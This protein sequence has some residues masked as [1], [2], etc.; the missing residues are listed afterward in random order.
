MRCP[1]CGGTL[2]IPEAGGGGPDGAAEG[3]EGGAGYATSYGPEREHGRP[4][5]IGP[6]SGAD[7]SGLGGGA[8]GGDGGAPDLAEQAVAAAEPAGEGGG[9]PAGDGQG[10]MASCPSCG[11]RLALARAHAG[12][13]MRCPACAAAFVVPGAGAPEWDAYL[14]P[15]PAAPPDILAGTSDTD[16]WRQEEAKAQAD[17]LNERFAEDDRARQERDDRG[18][19]MAAEDAHRAA[20]PPDFAQADVDRALAEQEQERQERDRGFHREELEGQVAEL[21]P[22]AEEARQR[23]EGRNRAR[24]EGAQRRLRGRALGAVGL[25]GLSGLESLADD[26]ADAIGFRDEETDKAEEAILDELRKINDV[27]EAI[28]RESAGDGAD[29]AERN[30]G[31]ES[32]TATVGGKRGSVTAPEERRASGGGGVGRRLAGAALESGAARRIAG[33]G[34]AGRLVSMLSRLLAARP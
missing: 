21:A 18:A 26:I 13:L 7:L 31:E 11:Q 34:A 32:A 30:T 1:Q 15:E 14:S 10:V 9:A 27:L 5:M 16:D 33:T 4:T 8:E 6:P 12:A 23:R 22:K 3:G 25:G 24:R 19:A 2:T 29:L 20:G 28:L 17:A